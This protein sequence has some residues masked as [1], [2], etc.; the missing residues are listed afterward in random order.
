MTVLAWIVLSWVAPAWADPTVAGP[1]VILGRSSVEEIDGLDGVSREEAEAVVALLEDRGG[2]IGSVEELRVIPSL[3]EPALNSLRKN[4]A[5]ERQ[6]FATGRRDYST[7]E[8]VLAEF[9]HE[10]AIQ[11]VQ[12]WAADYAQVSPKNVQRWLSASKTFA[13]LPQLTVEYRV[14][15]GWDQGFEYSTPDGA[16][17]PTAPKDDHIEVLNDANEDQDRTFYVRGRWDLDQLIMSSE[18][19]RIINETQDIAKLREKTLSDV[20]RLYFERRRIQ[21][22]N[23]LSA[24]KDMATAVKQELKLLELTANIDALTGGRFSQTVAKKAP[25]RTTPV[26]PAPAPAPEG[27]MDL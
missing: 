11:E 7:V 22:E 15:D 1:P 20:T 18:R 8:E 27:G 19:I 5:I 6:F 14:R 21:V 3:G 10:P 25:A 26:A 23:L 2:H 12:G 17:A 24:R 4:A 13:A 16:E 9:D